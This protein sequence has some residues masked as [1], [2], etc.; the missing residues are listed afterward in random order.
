M[1]RESNFVACFLH[2]CHQI[3]I[4]HRRDITYMLLVDVFSPES[5]DPVRSPKVWYLKDYDGLSHHY[6]SRISRIQPAS[7]IKSYMLDHRGIQKVANATTTNVCLKNPMRYGAFDTTKKAFTKELLGKCSLGNLC[8]LR[9]P[10]GPYKKLQFA[11]DGTSHT[12]NKAL[13]EQNACPSNMNLHEFYTFQMLRSGHRLQWRNI[14]TEI[15]AR[16]LDFGRI[17]NYLLMAQAAWQA[18]PPVACHS[19]FR[20]SHA[21]LED[22][23]FGTSLLLALDQALGTIEGNWQN[24]IAIRTFVVLAARVLSMSVDPATHHSCCS[25]LKRSRRITLEWARGVL[26]LAHEEQIQ[27]EL[28]I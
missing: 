18:G 17:E 28:Q 24:A 1:K 5:K 14:S 4:L 16:V 21:D 7:E 20:D 25:F 9:L 3:L 27:R 23:Q 6:N 12:S 22:A 11:M 19:V 10:L 15:I 8:T 26:K 13:A 2:R